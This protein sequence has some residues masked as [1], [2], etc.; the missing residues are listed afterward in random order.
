LGP[1]RRNRADYLHMTIRERRRRLEPDLTRP[2]Y[3]LTEPRIGYRL[4]PQSRPDQR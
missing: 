3:M 1:E 2:R 4:A